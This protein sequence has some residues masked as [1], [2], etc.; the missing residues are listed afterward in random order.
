MQRCIKEYCYILQN[1]SIILHSYV[2]VCEVQYKA[3]ACEHKPILLG[4][5]LLLTH[6]AQFS[7]PRYGKFLTQQ[8]AN[9]NCGCKLQMRQC[10]WMWSASFFYISTKDTNVGNFSMYGCWVR[11]SNSSR[12]NQYHCLWACRFQCTAAEICIH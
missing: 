4:K 6:N 1:S 7:L 10:G 12:S 3:R 11:C 8:K 2:L 9:S 5:T